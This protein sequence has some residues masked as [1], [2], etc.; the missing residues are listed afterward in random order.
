MLAWPLRSSP[1]PADSPSLKNPE[2]NRLSPTI[3]HAGTNFL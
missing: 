1:S 3:W 2:S